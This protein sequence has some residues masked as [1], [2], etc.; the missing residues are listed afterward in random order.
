MMVAPARIAFLVATLAFPFLAGLS[1]GSPWYVVVATAVIVLVDLPFRL[2]LE[3]RGRPLSAP[4]AFV[5][6]SF[7]AQAVVVGTVYVLGRGFASLFDVPR[8]MG[9]GPGI[10]WLLVATYAIG[11]FGAGAALLFLERRRSGTWP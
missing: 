6:R 9:F 2:R 4:L 7:L 8:T 10:N 5:V 1:W 3:F 11:L